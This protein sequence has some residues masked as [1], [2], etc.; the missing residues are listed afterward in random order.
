MK[1]ERRRGFLFLLGLGILGLFLASNA[2]AKVRGVSKDKI[3]MGMILVKTG[4][5]A[6]LGLP[7]R[8]KAWKT[9]SMKRTKR[10]A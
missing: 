1:M 8:V 6:A 7:N 3:M 2:A 10:A 5:V 4:P 9:P